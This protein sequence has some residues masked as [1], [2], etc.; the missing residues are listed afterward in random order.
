MNTWR[1]LLQLRTSILA[2]VPLAFLSLPV[3][4]AHL[5]AAQAQAKASP[6]LPDVVL[7]MAELPSAALSEFDFWD[8]P[9]SPGKKM[10]GTPNHGGDLDPPPENDPHVTMSAQVQASTPYRCWI[11][12]YVGKPKGMTAAHKTRRC[13]AT[14]IF[15]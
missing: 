3:A 14:K 15:P 10:V 9:A 2:L 4:N 7:Y 6:A 1:Y 13:T 8:G 11:H 5:T 12:M